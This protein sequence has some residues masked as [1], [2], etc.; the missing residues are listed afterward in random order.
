M[1]PRCLLGL[2]ASLKAATSD[3]VD[4]VP[5]PATAPGRQFGDY[6]LLNEIARGGM[7]VV[8]RARQKSLNRV[9][10]IKLLL[11]GEWASAEFVQRFLAEA[12]AAA[13][14]D[15]PGIVPIHEIGV[16]E[17]RHFIAMKFVDGE[18]LATKISKPGSRPTPH[19]AAGLLAK[20]ARTVHYAHQRGVL[21]RDLKPANVLIDARGEPVLTDFG[22]AK[23]LERD[24]Q[25]TRTL[26]V[27]GT[28]AYIAP[29]MAAGPGESTTAADVYGLGAIFYELLAGR[30]P[31][32]GGTPLEVLRQVTDTEAT[33]PSASVVAN[34]LVDRDLDTICLKCLE[35]DPARR[36]GSAEALADD[37]E[38]WLRSEP[39]LALPSGALERAG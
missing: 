35:K 30:P 11:G 26:S 20:L 18:S 34:H 25:L 31:F 24:G 7:G 17:G 1:C 14:L 33:A 22:L 21:H 2:G 19:D 10:A 16:H 13:R 8:Y 29:E 38:R 6:E 27:L 4:A 36:Y 28:P 39:L 12:E 23:L 37:L 32:A 15:H 9:V 3:G 5:E